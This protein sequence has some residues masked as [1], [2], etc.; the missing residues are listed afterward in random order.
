MTLN[1]R[2]TYR[3]IQGCWSVLYIVEALLATRLILFALEQEHAQGLAYFL[4]DI[5]K[6]FAAP[7]DAIDSITIIANYPMHLGILTAMTSYLVLVII[8]TRTLKR[9]VSE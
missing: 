1:Y 2:T 8:I 3:L 7:F 9:A 5:S 4:F 6:P